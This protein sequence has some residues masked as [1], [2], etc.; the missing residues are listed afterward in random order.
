M[1]EAIPLLPLSKSQARD[2]VTFQYAVTSR[3]VF[4]YLYLNILLS[5]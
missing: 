4:F 1:N 2:W 5:A 3:F